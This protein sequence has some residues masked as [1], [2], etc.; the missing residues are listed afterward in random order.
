MLVS[1]IECR[2]AMESETCAQHFWKH[3]TIPA[4]TTKDDKK[5]FYEVIYMKHTRNL[6]SRALDYFNSGD[7]LKSGRVA[8]THG[9]RCRPP[10]F[11]GFSK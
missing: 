4:C 5:S 8:S 11:D 10:W 1:G 6:L 9:V 3:Q 7:L 2:G